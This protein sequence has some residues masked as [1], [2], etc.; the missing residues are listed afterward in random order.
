MRFQTLSSIFAKIAN[1][2]QR[3]SEQTP[4]LS[5]NRELLNLVHGRRDVATSLLSFEKRRN[6]GHP[7]SWY[8]DKVI[9][10]LKRGR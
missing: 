9:Y 7:E 8:L 2:Y 4:G 10:D 5:L 3:V 6:P 1:Q